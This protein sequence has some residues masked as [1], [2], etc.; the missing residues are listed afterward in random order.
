MGA[1]QGP[2]F[3]PLSPEDPSE[4]AG[5]RLLA[6]LGEGG[7]GAVYL[8]RT[9][10]GQPVAIKVVRREYARDAAFRRRFA[11]EVRAASRVRGY[12]LVAV[13]DHDSEAAAPW[14]ASEYV[15]GVG[16]DEALAARGPLPLDAVLK[17]TAC[18]A[19]A[20]ATIHAAGV[21]HRDLKPS[22][23]MLAASGPFVIDFGIARAADATQLTTTGGLIGTPHYMSPE[24]ALGDPVGPAGDVFALGLVAAVAA[25]GRHPYGD[26][27][28][29]T[30]ATQIANTAV[31]P[32][33]LSGYPDALRPL[34]ERALT[35]SPDER[36]TPGE[37][38][39]LC[40]GAAER[41]LD[42]F[43][44]WLPG[45]L[46]RSL[47]ERAAEVERLV[48]APAPPPPASSAPLPPLPPPPGSAL[49]ATGRA[50]RPA[51]PEPP[52][53]KKRS[54]RARWAWGGAV[55]AAA[56]V[57]LVLLAPV[58][59]DLWSDDSGAGA[60][61]N[62]AGES[63]EDPPADDGD[64][65]TPGTPEPEP[66]PSTSEPEPEPRFEPL[67]EGQPFEI[68]AVLYDIIFV[69]LDEARVSADSDD[70][71]DDE[72]SISGY[73]DAWSLET[74][75][76]ISAGTSPEEC[77]DATQFNV[78]SPEINFDDFADTLPVGTRL[79]F[80]TTSGNL[81]Q[82]EITGLTVSG[83]YDNLYDVS[84]VLTVWAVNQ[85]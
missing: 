57:A 77:Q 36:I 67:M 40:A 7:M 39:A 16:L 21:V 72:L 51:P 55:A 53:P 45:E 82:L 28:G 14:L 41:P 68:R 76:G 54:G 43:G 18:V 2:V 59:A 26:G 49:A 60:E 10:G 23:I 74:T 27:G 11:Q 52:R 1:Q 50:A 31:R 78:M 84:T 20:L 12:H 70:S 17:V 3:K 32:P 5:Q 38:E 19:R 8:S 63:P 58:V 33:D 47:A 46:A 35:A 75:A 6:R 24:Q 62:E 64:G 71:D 73:S 4:V 85:P 42:D 29:I 44:G 65:E 34:L 61:G 81:A 66:E 15:A 9:R 25:T 80:I 48:R 30:V 22:N 83:D 37:V 56:A 69:D 79:C 13:V